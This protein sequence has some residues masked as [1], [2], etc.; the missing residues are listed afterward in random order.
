MPLVT[1]AMKSNLEGCIGTF[2]ITIANW[3]WPCKNKGEDIRFVYKS[4]MEIP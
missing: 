3:M 4:M 2:D 1:L